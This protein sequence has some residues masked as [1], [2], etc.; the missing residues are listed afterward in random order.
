MFGSI[1]LLLLVDANYKSVYIDTGCQGCLSDGTILRYTSFYKAI[2][3]N[4][5]N[6]LDPRTSQN[7]SN[8]NGS[9]RID[10]QRQ[11]SVRYAFGIRSVCVW[12]PFGM[13]LQQVIPLLFP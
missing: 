1:V 12:Y 3:T 7:L 2:I 11:A 5:V 4:L 8:A 13:C 9:F 10:S 6:L